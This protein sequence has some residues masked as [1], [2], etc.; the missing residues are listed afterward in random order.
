MYIRGG[1]MNYSTLR[2]AYSI[3]TFEKERKPKIKKKQK[4]E[5]VEDP[6]EEV[7][8]ET[9]EPEK[10]TEKSQKTSSEKEVISEKLVQPF[11]DEE[12]EKYLNVNDF[13]DTKPY[14]P[15]TF[16]DE[17]NKTNFA[18]NNEIDVIVKHEP[19][20]KVRTKVIDDTKDIFYKNLI[21]IGLFVL[22][23]IMIIFLCDQ[24]TEIAINI[25][26]KKTISIIEPYLQHHRI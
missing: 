24:I 19:V 26:M 13:Q 10:R 12:L 17:Q 23:G 4:Y 25:G 7:E 5:V 21:N 1:M 22:I 8:H 16:S 20:Q 14:I 9:Q 11:Y 18:P 6:I 15:Q 2:E 3:D